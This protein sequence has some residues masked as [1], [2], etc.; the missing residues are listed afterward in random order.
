MQ[1]QPP[2]TVIAEGRRWLKT[3][4]DAEART[5]VYA[6]MLEAARELPNVRQGNAV[7][8]SLLKADRE[9]YG[10]DSVMRLPGMYLA[11]AWY[12][13]AGRNTDEQRLL[14]E[15]VSLLETAAGPTDAR[16]AYPLRRLADSCIRDGRDPA[17]ARA[18]LDRGLGLTLGTAR[19]E[20]RERAEAFAARGDWELRFGER[21]AAAAWYRTAWQKLAD[22]SH[23]G[24]AAAN[25]AF[26]EPVPLVVTVPAKPFASLRRDPDFYAP[27]TVE[28]GFTV[29]ADGAVTDLAL[30]RSTAPIDALPTPL[31]RALRRAQ[32]RPA[33]RDGAPR[34]TPGHGY[35]FS[36]AVDAS[37]PARAIRAGP[38]DQRF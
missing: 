22:S 38:I 17:V 16:L 13:G 25:A 1:G 11:A 31:E 29:T 20:V 23:F 6:T 5:R 32:Y 19:D 28:Y 8:A 33:I 12:G 14:G 2:V 30:R 7:A 26:G 37:Q 18:A 4:D 15:A 3:A 27:G 36:F 10:A 24:P 34:P 21:S 35:A 9:R